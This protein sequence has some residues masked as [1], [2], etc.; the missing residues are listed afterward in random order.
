[1]DDSILDMF[2]S[3]F[4]TVITVMKTVSFWGVPV[5]YY[6]LGFLVI[7]TVI[8]YVVNTAKSPPIERGSSQRFRRDVRNSKKGG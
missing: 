1:M 7:G 3:V 4:S 6:C 2:F 8:A 5:F